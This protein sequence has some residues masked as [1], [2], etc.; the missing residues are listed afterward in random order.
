MPPSVNDILL[1]RMD[2]AIKNKCIKVKVIGK[3]QIHL[4]L[5]ILFSRILASAIYILPEYFQNKLPIIKVKMFCKK[6]LNL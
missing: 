3:C 5:F 2:V 4:K 1:F 6:D